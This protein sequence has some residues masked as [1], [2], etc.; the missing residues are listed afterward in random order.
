[1]LII[2]RSI[3]FNVLFYLAI[4]IHLALALP[5]FLM[6]YW[7]IVD[8]AKVWAR[9]NL[10]LLRTICRIDV[11]FAGLNKIPSGPLIVAAKH[12]SFWETFAFLLVFSRPTY[13]VKRELMWIPLFGWFM[14]KGRMVPV[15]RGARRQ[16][17]RTMT[18]R[19]RE[20]LRRA[21][22]A[23]KTGIA[24][25]YAETGVACVPVALNSGLYWGRRSFKR[26]PGTI[27][28]EI[29]DPIPAGLDKEAFLQRLEHD[30]E[31]ATARL[32]ADAA[33]QAG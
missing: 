32:V 16:A 3:L 19:A 29:I 18:R 31:T 21:P 9:T 13:I 23:Y 10:W 33:P 26:Y 8:L 7:V 6:P 11:E 5:T 4:L 22:P 1:V 20:E 12:Q 28:V 15:D 2:A 27:R 14:W 24:H 17:L 25:L 30:I